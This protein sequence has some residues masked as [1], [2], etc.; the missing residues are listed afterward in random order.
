MLD[1]DGKATTPYSF[2]ITNNCDMAVNYMVSLE[3]I[4]NPNNPNDSYL[5]DDYIDVYFDDGNIYPYGSL[6]T[7]TNDT[8]TGY[9]IRSTRKI[10]AE[11][12]YAHESKTHNLRIWLDEDTPQTQMNKG[13]YS[14]VKVVSGQGIDLDC[15]AVNS[16]GVL[17]KY[18]PDCGMKATI[19]AEVNGIQVKKIASTAFTDSGYPDY[20][21]NSRDY[22]V[23]DIDFSI[24]V[25]PTYVTAYYNSDY[26]TL[27]NVT[28]NDIKFLK[29]KD[30]A[31][32]HIDD[33]I[34]WLKN[35]PDETI[36][37]FYQMESISSARVSEV[38][39]YNH[40]TIRPEGY[41]HFY[42]VTNDNGQYIATRIG[43]KDSAETAGLL[44]TNIAFLDLSQATN[45]VEIGNSAFSE[46]EMFGKTLTMPSSLRV[47]GQG[48]FAKISVSQLILNDGLQTIGKDAFV[49]AG[50][51][52]TLDIPSS[53]TEIGYN[54]FSNNSSLTITVHNQDLYN[55]RSSWAPVAT[56]VYEP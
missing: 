31:S 16:D 11:K 40:D 26:A 51:F 23:D 55:T 47:I 17:T 24:I 37:S 50:G 14:K 15:Y 3:S 13:F 54:A 27:S 22:G 39:I 4:A 38:K 41:E 56:V 18:N 6:P 2:T 36:N 32:G 48:A 35:N 42:K 49:E 52:N 9:T 21:F 19:P 28:S 53:V 5:S 25:N 33:A 10:T 34:E 29:Y 44:A 20:T 43:N 30:D 7:I 46:L 1:A 8:S 45:L 12:L